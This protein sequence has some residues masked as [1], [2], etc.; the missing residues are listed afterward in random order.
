MR[1]AP[2]R[3][4]ASVSPLTTSGL[5]TKTSRS[6]PGSYLRIWAIDA[7]SPG[8]TGSLATRIRGTP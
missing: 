6:G 2:E 1:I 3:R 5:S 8:V 4:T 7:K